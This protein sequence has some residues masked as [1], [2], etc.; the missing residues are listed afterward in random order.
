MTIFLQ[1]LLV[2]VTSFIFLLLLWRVLA[3]A[4]VPF[5][6]TML[7]PTLTGSASPSL[8]ECAEIFGYS[9]LFRISILI[10][11]ML[12]FGLFFAQG[13][14]FDFA[15]WLNHWMQWDANNY[16]RIADGYTSFTESGR[17]TTLVFFPLYSFF[18]NLVNYII[19][20]PVISGLLVSAVAS[21]IAVVYFY[22]LVCIDYSRSTA[23]TASVLLC[24]FPFGFFYSSIMSESVFLCTSV[25]TLYYIRKHDWWLAGI[26]GCLSALSRSIGVFL[27]F[28]AAVELLEETRLLGNIKNKQV[29]LDILKKG[30]WILL[31]PVG[32]LIHL[33]INYQIT[34]DPLYFLAMEKEIWFQTSQPFYKIASTLWGVFQ[35][36]YD[37][38]F[39]FATFVPAIFI[40]IGIYAL[41]IWG[42]NKHK[43]MYLCW[44]L[45]SVLVNCSMSWPISLPRYLTNIVPIYI[46][47]ADESE[48]H[49]KLKSALLVGFGVLF[50]IFL[51]GYLSGK[52]I[53]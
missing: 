51:V 6:K 17:F 45:V 41:M 46:I 11:S 30:G 53:L 33:Y 9:M 27:V 39:L 1:I 26:F 21:S 29:W 50:G 35:S 40:L 3:N 38:P 5:P 32:T 49:P 20:S 16:V 22:K 36:G 12:I 43:T 8:K 48:K 28:P 10:A 23:H 18:L 42:I 13:K 25:I 52:S 14:T 47:L 7:E 19:P 34:G 24:I 15:G 44:I 31:F 4:G 37:I 2:L